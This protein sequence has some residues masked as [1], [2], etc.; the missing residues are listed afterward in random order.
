MEK[1]FRIEPCS[2]IR[3]EV[4]KGEKIVIIDVEGGQV[5]DF[6][7]EMRGNSEEFVSPGVTMD[8]NESLKLHVG[9]T[10]YSNRYRPMFKVLYDDVKEHDL[11]HPLQKRMYDFFITME[12]VIPIVST[13]LMALALL[14][15]SFIRS[16]CY[17]LKDHAD[18]PFQVLRPL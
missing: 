18:A 9:D 16:I 17:A 15:R 5:V 3:L 7:A 8:C 11:F 12:K 6:F 4:S 13:I 1:R 2:G 10:I 14:I